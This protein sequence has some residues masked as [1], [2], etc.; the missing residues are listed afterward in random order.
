MSELLEKLLPAERSHH[1]TWKQRGETGD[2]TTAAQNGIFQ[3]I[4]ECLRLQKQHT[5]RELLHLKEQFKEKLQFRH[6]LLTQRLL[7]SCF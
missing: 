1:R 7:E 5:V 4:S 2:F 6:H 3:D